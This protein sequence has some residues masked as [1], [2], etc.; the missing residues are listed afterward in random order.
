M[1]ARSDVACLRRIAQKWFRL[2]Y[3]QSFRFLLFL[4]CITL[5]VD[6]SAEITLPG[7]LHMTGTAEMGFSYDDNPLLGRRG[8]FL[9]SPQGGSRGGGETD[10]ALRNAV[11]LDV[12]RRLGGVGDRI[13]AT[14]RFELAR[15]RTEDQLRGY[16]A[17]GS[18]AY[19]VTIGETGSLEPDVRLVYQRDQPEWSY[20]A[21]QPGLA[22]GY[23][24]DCGLL[25]R[26][27]YRFT[28]QEYAKFKN[29]RPEPKNSY[30]N[31]DV[32][33]HFADLELKLWHTQWLRSQL[34]FDVQA[35]RYDGNLNT[36]LADYAGLEPGTARKDIGAG[37]TA[38]VLVAPVL[39][40]LL[41][42]PGLRLEMNDSN[43]DSF[44]YRAGHLLLN[45]LWNVAERHRFFVR[46]DYS[47]Y[48]FPDAVFDRR[49]SNTRRDFRQEITASYRFAA[50]D[51]ITAELVYRRA[52][53][54]S[55]DCAAFDPQRDEFGL[56]VF[57]RSFSCFEQNRVGLTLKYAF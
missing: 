56:P 21:V 4:V 28:T 18:V 52:E 48:D 36:N 44:T 49:F 26:L 8:Q 20:R 35:A 23:S 31:I 29:G 43:S 33:S 41:V 53:S 32:D 37:V 25:T 13:S 47:T 38:A 2:G 10:I 34:T 14:G 12:F 55:N 45:A 15:L 19:R 11:E 9:D 7:E 16:S 22:A 5:A 17:A 46:W 54:T 6:A 57:S 1:V 24:F 51:A 42:S 40:G 30:G 3:L 27:R 50:T 39:H